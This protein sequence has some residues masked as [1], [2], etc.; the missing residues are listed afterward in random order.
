PGARAE[1]LLG[2][3]VRFQW[4]LGPTPTFEYKYDAPIDLHITPC[5][6][7]DVVHSASL[8]TVCDDT[9]TLVSY[10]RFNSQW[11]TNGFNGF[12]LSDVDGSIAPLLSV[13]VLPLTN[14]PRFDL[15]RVT[16]L[17]DSVAVNLA[18]LDNTPSTT[19]VLR[20]TGRQISEPAT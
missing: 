17:D 6:S 7:F 15:S 19:L 1:L 20:I 13:E 8:L 5:D 18:S 14:L 3:D 2:H 12:V 11:N 10:I 9:I 4:Y 16:L